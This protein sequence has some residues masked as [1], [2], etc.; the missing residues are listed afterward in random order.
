MKKVIQLR[1]NLGGRSQIWRAFLD[2]NQAHIVWGVENGKELESTRTVHQGKQGRSAPEQLESEVV[3]IARKKIRTRGY[4]LL[5][6]DTGLLVQQSSE[7]PL[8]MLARPWDELKCAQ[9]MGSDQL[10]YIQPKLDGLRCIADLKTGQLWSRAHKRFECGGHI[11]EAVRAA[12]KA[13]GN[14][15]SDFRFL[16]GELYRHGWGFQKITSVARRTTKNAHSDQTQLQLH[17]FDVCAAQ[18]T[19]KDRFNW[20][21]SVLDS[22]QDSLVM[23]ET[24]SLQAGKLDVQEQLEHYESQGYEGIM[25]RTNQPGYQAGQRSKGLWKVKSFLQ[26]EFK[27]VSFLKHRELDILGSVRLQDSTGRNFSAAPAKTLEVKSEL[28]ENRERYQDGLW[29]ATV[30]FDSYTKDGVPRFPVLCGLRHLHDT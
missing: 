19:F 27:V 14:I 17:V 16:D 8:P 3:A 2:G 28:W 9:I 26:E 22:S 10:L 11:E 1:A 15:E 12:G 4:E 29:C 23:C 5:Q 18:S 13:L 6:D 25:V 7:V 24:R 21:T 30:K 20:L